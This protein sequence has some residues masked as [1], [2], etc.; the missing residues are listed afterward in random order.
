MKLSRAG[1]I[2]SGLSVTICRVVG[3]TAVS[4][5]LT[6]R[7]NFSRTLQ[8]WPAA[9]ISGP[10]TRL[11]DLTTASALNGSPSWKVTPSRSLKRHFV[12]ST[13]SHEVAR[14]G[15]SLPSLPLLS[16]RVSTMLCLMTG[17]SKERL[18]LQL[19]SAGGSAC[20]ST[21][22]HLLLM[23]AGAWVCAWAGARAATAKAVAAMP[24]SRR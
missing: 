24:A 5:S 9:F 20:T 17:P 11:I 3:S 21:V 23:A 8:N 15:L 13:C 22:T 12:G 4:S 14:R 2:G 7:K 16:T 18:E 1:R 19:S 6:S 10:S